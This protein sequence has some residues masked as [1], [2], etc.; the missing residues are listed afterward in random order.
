[1]AGLLC[2]GGVFFLVNFE[3]VRLR[4]Y[5]LPSLGATVPTARDCAEA[6]PP[7]LGRRVQGIRFRPQLFCS[8]DL[9]IFCCWTGAIA[10]DVGFCAV[11]TIEW[12]LRVTVYL[13][14]PRILLQ[15]P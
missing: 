14:L 2:R 7:T 11:D 5:C 8:K 4:V 6:F 9:A 12:D 15:V 1:M 13:E 10:G 3:G